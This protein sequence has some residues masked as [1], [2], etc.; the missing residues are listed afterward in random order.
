MNEY[1]IKVDD[2]IHNLNVIREKAAGAQVIGVVKG[3]GYGFGLKFMAS[4][5]KSEG[6]TMFAVTEPEDLL[7]LREDALLHEDILVMRDTAIREELCAIVEAEGIATVGSPESALALEQA[8]VSADKE[9]RAYLKI[10]TGMARY[11]FAP[12]NVPAI[13]E[14]VQGC[15][16]VKFIGIYT[17]FS[18]AFTQE[19]L[20]RR[21]MEQ[22]QTVIARLRE[23]GIEPGA[24]C[25]ANSPALF[26]VSGSALDQ[27]RVGSALT[28]RVITRSPSGLKRAGALRSQ[29]VSVKTVPKGTPISYNGA[30]RTKRETR[31]ATVPVGH[32]DGFAL[33][34]A[35][36][37]NSLATFIRACLSQAKRFVLR[38]RLT[39]QIHG[40]ACPVLGHVGLSHTTVDVTGLEV[41]PGDTVLIDVPP[42]YVSP[43]LKRVYE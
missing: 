33:D 32:N 36:D 29:V 30:Y 31:L 7:S 34:K 27:V 24:A 15:E 37:V 28:G 38:E 19:A 2:V 3:N 11:G 4:L 35:Q 26:N 21:Q 10:D 13:A 41:K 12:D 1:V 22:F 16:H 25:A 39:V 43:M 9:A 8:A 17:H 14:A 23:I 5:L 20:T 42:L 40:K 6:V 18:S